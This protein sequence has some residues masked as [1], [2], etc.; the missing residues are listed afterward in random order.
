MHD[1]G[2]VAVHKDG[3][4]GFK[5]LAGGGLG[6]KPYHAITVEEFVEEKDLLASMEA[7]L[8]L[9][10]KYSD[11]KRRA[12]ARI[13]FLT[14]KIGVEGYLEKYRDELA[15][16]KVAY[17][18]YDYPKGEWRAGNFDF[19]FFFLGVFCGVFFQ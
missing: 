17:A 16:T 6:H 4:F 8:T 11:R 3:R 15:R 2:V 5:I 18:D 10:N 1:I 12:R 14:D 7:I 19:V 9:H 13:K